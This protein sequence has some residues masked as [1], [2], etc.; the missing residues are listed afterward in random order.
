M[1]PDI[2]LYKL[3]KKRTCDAFNVKISEIVSNFYN[4]IY[5]FKMYLTAFNSQIIKYHFNFFIGVFLGSIIIRSAL[6]VSLSF[7][8]TLCHSMNHFW[9]FYTIH[10]TMINYKT[11]ISQ[12]MIN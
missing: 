3:Q 6:E 11:I 9:M 8:N 12:I 4:F 2:R 5:L 7:I 1:H 10:H